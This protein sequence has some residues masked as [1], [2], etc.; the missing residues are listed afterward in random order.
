MIIETIFSTLDPAGR[1]NFAPMGILWGEETLTVRPFRD[2]LTY[3]NLIATGY[4][5]VNLTDNVLAF[6]QSALSNAALPHFPASIAP[7][8]VYQGACSWREV[9]VISD[10]GTLERA[11]ISCR[12]VH[13]ERLRD[14]LG[15]CRAGGVVIESAILATRLNQYAP[16]AI[17]E[18]LRGYARIVEKTGG[19]N[20]MLAFQQVQNYIRSAINHD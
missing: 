9:K 19:E 3:R 2:T 12:V 16:E 8:V 6:V 13:Q 5:V 1:P 10:S 11:E 7:G 4:G 20:E 17:L 14:F 15:F 18:T